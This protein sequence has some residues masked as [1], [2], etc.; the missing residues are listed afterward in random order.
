MYIKRRRIQ[1]ICN[2]LLISIPKHIRKALSLDKG[3]TVQ[4]EWDT[5]KDYFTVKKIQ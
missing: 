3:D 1:K 5:H 4:I 2:T